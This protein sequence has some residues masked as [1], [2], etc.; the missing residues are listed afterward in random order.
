MTN[1]LTMKCRA[2]KKNKMSY[3]GISRKMCRKCLRQDIIDQVQ[4]SA[5]I[6]LREHQE[7][8]EAILDG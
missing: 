7:R 2:C 4:K 1:Q 8:K 6:V 3:E 5:K